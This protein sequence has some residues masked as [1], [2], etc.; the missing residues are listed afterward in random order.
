MPSIAAWTAAARFRDLYLPAVDGDKDLPHPA[1]NHL[2]AAVHRPRASFR[3]SAVRRAPANKG[4]G[5]V[6]AAQGPRLSH[7]LEGHVDTWRGGPPH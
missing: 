4:E 2:A 1:G 3:A 6:D 5:L 7:Q